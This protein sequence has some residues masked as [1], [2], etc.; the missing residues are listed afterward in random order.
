MSS[1]FARICWIICKWRVCSVIISADPPRVQ[2]LHGWIAENALGGD[3]PGFADLLAA[4]CSTNGLRLRE[5]GFTPSSVESGGRP[6]A[7]L[8]ICGDFFRCYRLERVE[9]I[10]S[11]RDARHL[12]ILSASKVIVILS[13]DEPK[14]MT[15]ASPSRSLRSDASRPTV[16]VS[17]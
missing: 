1:K 9:K 4:E 8:T 7:P 2:F 16:C 15:Q 11:G 3:F 10:K 12:P 14:R 13:A 6:F 17:N 5:P